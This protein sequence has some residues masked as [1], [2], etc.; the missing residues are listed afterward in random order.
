MSSGG[1]MAKEAPSHT[2][3]AEAT[4]L[5]HCF[6]LV[7]RQIALSE[8]DFKRFRAANQRLSGSH[9][10]VRAVELLALAMRFNRAPDGAGA[11]AMAQLTVLASDLMDAD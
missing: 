8:G 4:E 10:R 3:S 9:R 1:W 5:V 7:G 6:K 2:L 11:E